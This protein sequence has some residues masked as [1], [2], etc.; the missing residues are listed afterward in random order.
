MDLLSELA[1]TDIDPALLAQVR[2]LLEQQQGKLAHKDAL[3]AEK[4]FAGALMTIVYPPSSLAAGSALCN[5]A[6]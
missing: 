1:R 6:P 5:K 4:D 2:T 3:L